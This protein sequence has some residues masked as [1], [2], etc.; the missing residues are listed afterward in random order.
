MLILPYWVSNLIFESLR[1][2]QAFQKKFLEILKKFEKP[3]QF[4]S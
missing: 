4:E 1:H 3:Q 2:E